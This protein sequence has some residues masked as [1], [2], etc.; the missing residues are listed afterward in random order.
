MTKGLTGGWTDTPL[1]EL[2]RTQAAL[3]GQKLQYLKCPYGFYSSDLKRAAETAHIIG[4]HLDNQPVLVPNLREHNN[5]LAANKTREKADKIKNPVTDPVMDWI[6][7]PEAESWR[8][9]H[10]R[11]VSFM[12]SIENTHD[13]VLIVAHSLVIVSIIHWWL[14]FDED[15]MTR[16]SYDSDVCCITELYINNW[17]EKTIGKLNDTSHLLALEK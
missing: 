3:T 6:P 17:G 7:Y 15:I 10:A 16:V 11:V 1:T 12:D 8:M 5:G 9:L 4:E 2:G 14:K 13:T